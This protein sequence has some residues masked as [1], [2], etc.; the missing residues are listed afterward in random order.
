MR[1]FRLGL[2]QMEDQ[3]RLL[4]QE[5]IRT[6]GEMRRTRPELDVAQQRLAAQPPTQTFNPLIHILTFV[7]LNVK[8]NI[9][10]EASDS[11]LCTEREVAALAVGA[12]HAGEEQSLR[13]HSGF[14]T[15]STEV[16]KRLG[17]VGFQ[18]RDEDDRSW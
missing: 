10:F 13:S 11:R 2:F 9:S 1:T 5:M 3:L 7:V 12:V 8:R 4:Q 17:V 18:N 6:Q 14:L 16:E 15:N